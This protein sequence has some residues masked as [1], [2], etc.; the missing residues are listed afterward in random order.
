MAKN[1]PGVAETALSSVRVIEVIAVVITVVGTESRMRRLGLVLE[2][3]TEL[4]KGTVRALLGTCRG[5]GGVEV[6]SL[7]LAE[8]RRI[9]CGGGLWL[10]RVG[11]GLHLSLGVEV[12]RKFVL[13]VQRSRIGVQTLLWGN[14]GG[15]GLVVVC[16]GWLRD[17]LGLWGK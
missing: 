16:E 7:L 13:V 5:S 17:R 4:P 1:V 8:M 10:R 9:A 11:G 6:G 2:C 15:L 3:L 12:G 14:M